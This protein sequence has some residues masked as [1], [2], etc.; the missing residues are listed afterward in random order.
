MADDYGS[1]LYTEL[2]MLINEK[3]DKRKVRELVASRISD[4]SSHN[5]RRNLKVLSD[6]SS[7]GENSSHHGRLFNTI[8]GFAREGSIGKL[9]SSHGDADK[10]KDREKMRDSD[11][12]D[13]SGI[14][15]WNTGHG[16]RKNAQLTKIVERDIENQDFIP[17]G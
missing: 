13:A 17:E 14:E 9:F 10:D 12:S 11:M 16:S 3:E 6:F 7:H 4:W 5:G 2:T 8:G 1:S 15:G